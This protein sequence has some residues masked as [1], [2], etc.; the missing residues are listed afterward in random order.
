[1][2]FP[3]LVAALVAAA[4]TAHAAE[5]ARA[6]LTISGGAALRNSI[7]SDGS[8]GVRFGGLSATQGRLTLDYFFERSPVGLSVE[9]GG[10]RFNVVGQNLARTKDVTVT[11]TGLRAS[12]AIAA[13]WVAAS[14]LSAEGQLGYGYGAVP[15]LD[16]TPT[17]VAAAQLRH[18][19]P[20]LGVRL[21][22]DN[23]GLVSAA[24][25]GRVA[26]FAVGATYLGTSLALTQIGAGAE[27]AFGRFQLSKLKVAALLD[28]ELSITSASAGNYKTSQTAHRGGIGL[29]FVLPSAEP[30][31]VEPPP[32]S[33]PGVLKGRVVRAGGR[34]ASAGTRVEVA[35]HAP[36]TVDTTGAFRFEG[37]G[38]GKV[39]VRASAEGFESV[40]QEAE[41][42]PGGEADAQLVL[43]KPVGPGS[44]K[45]K[46][47]IAAPKGPAANVPV[48]VAGK[49]P[50]TTGADGSFVI[51][52]VGPG[53]VTVKVQAAG[54]KP[55]EEVV[56]IPPGG[57][58]EVTLTLVKVGAPKPLAVL[59]GLVRTEAGAPVQASVKIP[60]ANA[61]LKAG[62]DGRFVA[63]VPGGKYTVLIEAPGF[64]SQTKVVSV[65]DG[66]Q[67]IFI[68][69]LRRKVQ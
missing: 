13:R 7:Q 2:R 50:V 57:E 48:E 14:G 17:T 65:A 24:L 61:T 64:V 41:V 38:P 52:Q 44:L 20:L 68:C 22:F 23:G 55:A 1:M 51:A 18:H 3:L 15:Q 16:V 69:D 49:P 36:V 29:R 12:A 60:E 19:G 62:P 27:L 25:R 35:G 40:E 32:P 26:P 28:Y 54:F 47:L 53:P 63:H 6:R 11:E 42:P 37:V 9:A 67:A 33:G 10:E 58:A 59:R 34:A 5:P 43:S 31:R 45:G 4:V 8:L 46:V 39:T 21:G 30:V 56:S 66:E